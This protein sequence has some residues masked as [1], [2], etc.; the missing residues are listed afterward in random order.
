MRS[1]EY[2]SRKHKLYISGRPTLRQMNNFMGSMLTE[3]NVAPEEFTVPHNICSAFSDYQKFKIDK[4][5]IVVHDSKKEK[6][7][8]GRKQE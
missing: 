1:F 3:K 5:Y 6:K 8:Q 7:D 4:T 2:F